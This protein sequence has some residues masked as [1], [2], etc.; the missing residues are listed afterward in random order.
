MPSQTQGLHLK[1]SL[2]HE[3]L[4]LLISELYTISNRRWEDLPDLKRKKVVLASRLQHFD[5]TTGAMEEESF[6]VRR[7]KSLV[8]D[9]E[10]QSRQKI[11]AQIELIEN[12][13]LALQELHQYWRE[14]LNISFQ[15]FCGPPP[16]PEPARVP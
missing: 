2:L 7:L 11:Q 15:K 4:A 13:I 10:D 3:V 9:L 8:T 6:D 12:Q 1:T 14:S 5:D 16:R